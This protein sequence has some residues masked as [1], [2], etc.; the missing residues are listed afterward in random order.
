MRPVTD[1]HTRRRDPASTL[2][3]RRIDQPVAQP[4][5]PTP[6]RL[7]LFD[8]DGTLAP[9]KSPIAVSTATLLVRLLERVDVCIISGGAFP[10][11]RRQ[12]LP[13][14]GSSPNLTRLHLMPTCGTQYYRWRPGGWHQV[15]AEL[16]DPA[17]KDRIIR[18][19]DDGARELGVAEPHPWGEIIED[20][21]TQITYSAL[22][23]QAPLAAKAAWDPSG[24][25]RNGL[26][27]YAAGRLPDLEVRVGGSTSIDVTARGIDKAYGVRKLEHY[28]HIS[29]DEML[30]LGD[31]LDVDGNDYPV[32][33][34]GVPCIAVTGWRD[35]GRHIVDLLARQVP[36]RSGPVLQGTPRAGA[37]RPGAQ[38]TTSGI[39][40][41]PADG[42][43]APP[44][45]TEISE[46]ESP[47]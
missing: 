27:D 23:Q 20:R 17:L 13:S 5:T 10:Q 31:R 9:S 47:S 8:L 43:R 3:P 28:L 12:V 39:P 15:Y 26:R 40:S 42:H 7:V 45:S 32:K 38:F 35:T 29:L 33:A 18:V 19:L 1:H 16:L 11:F 44:T 22:G 34:T 30:F 4:P 14:L 6:V 37:E 21:A 24:N 25:K 41:T 2:A 36:S 46:S